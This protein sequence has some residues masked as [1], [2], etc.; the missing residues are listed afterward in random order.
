V[1][2]LKGG[3]PCSVAAWYETRGI[4]VPA[5]LTDDQWARVAP[6]VGATATQRRRVNAIL[7]K[8]RTRCT[9]RDVQPFYGSPNMARK[10]WT[11]WSTGLWAKVDEQLHDAERTDWTPTSR[12]VP[13]F[14]VHAEVD[15]RILVVGEPSRTGSLGNYQDARPCLHLRISCGSAQ[16]QT[17]LS[18]A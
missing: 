18:A 7:H 1:P 16:S 12:P 6:L 11:E 8:A 17:L 5:E 2:I 15:P 4:G 14:V 13:D 9:W 10:A 3:H